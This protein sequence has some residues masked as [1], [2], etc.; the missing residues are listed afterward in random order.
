MRERVSGEEKK[1]DKAR[2][3]RR[4]GWGVPTA[5]SVERSAKNAVTMVV[6]D[7]FTPFTGPDHEM[8]TFRMH[9]LPWPAEV[10]DEIG[11]ADVELR[12]TLSY[13][14]EP[15]ASR[16]G[17]RQR[18]AYASHGLRFEMRRPLESPS[19]FLNRVNRQAKDE[20]GG[21]RSSS[22]Q[23][24]WILG[25]QHRHR[26]SLHQDVWL[27][28]GTELA[29]TGCNIA[30]HAVGGWWKNNKRKDRVDL[31]VRY[32]LLV[33]LRTEAQGVDLYEP[34]AVELGVPTEA[35]AMEA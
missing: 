33:S 11:E 12:V 35:I 29:A 21:S 1:K 4:Y 28:H 25:T 16:R 30:V 20:E 18:Y 15:S 10:L 17:W 7:T 13:F 14:V 19:D 5:E 32:A 26:G 3:L 22:D 6:Q 9:R 8:R 24:Q 23:D 31:P 2:M 34:I 27:G